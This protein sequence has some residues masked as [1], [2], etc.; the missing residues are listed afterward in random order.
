MSLFSLS[1]MMD[2]EKRYQA[3]CKEI[4]IAASGP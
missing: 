4:V 2:G 3:A 1:E